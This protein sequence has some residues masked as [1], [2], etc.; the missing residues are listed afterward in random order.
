[1]DIYRFQNRLSL[2]A[3]ESHDVC[4]VRFSEIKFEESLLLISPESFV[5]SSAM[6]KQKHLNMQNYNFMF[7]ALKRWLYSCNRSWRPIGLWDVEAPTLSRQS[8]HRWQW[9]CQPAALYPPGRF[10]VLI[11]VRGW[12]D[13]RDIVR[14]EGLGQ[15]ENS[16]TSLEIEPATF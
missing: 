10:L 12:V 7:S 3:G 9:D 1:M 11:S 6:Q 4:Y 14:L 2:L 8:A 15:L 16:M 5:F 13:S